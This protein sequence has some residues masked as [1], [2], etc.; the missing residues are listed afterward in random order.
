MMRLV[1]AFYAMMVS[2]S[3][4]MGMDILADNFVNNIN[5]TIFKI[6]FN[7]G[8]LNWQQI[9]HKEQQANAGTLSVRSNDCQSSEQTLLTNW[10]RYAHEN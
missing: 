2:T 6:F 4:I 9:V 3:Q 1:E 7:S 10:H 8:N 5:S